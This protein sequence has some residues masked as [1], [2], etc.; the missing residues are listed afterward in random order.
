MAAIGASKFLEAKSLVRPL[1]PA[2]IAGWLGDSGVCLDTAAAVVEELGRR[3]WYSFVVPRE[4]MFCERPYNA[5]EWGF[6]LLL[7][8][9]AALSTTMCVGTAYVFIR[10]RSRRCSHRS[11]RSVEVLHLL[12]PPAITAVI[13]CYLPNE[14]H[15]IEE[16]V[17]WIMRVLESPGPLELHVVYNTPEDLPEVEARLQELQAMVWPKDRRFRATRV[18]ESTSKAANLNFAL[19]DVESPF[20]V[21]YDAD[22]HPDA[23][24]LM[25]LWR[26]LERTSADCVQGSYY[27]R[28]LGSSQFAGTTAA[29]SLIAR[30]VDAEF[31]VD[32][33][34]TKLVTRSLF[35]GSG[36]FSGSNALWRTAALAARE[37]SETAQTEDVDM[38]VQQLLDGRRIEFCPESRSGELAPTGCLALWKQRLRWTIGWDETSLKYG[39]DFADAANLSTRARCGLVWTFLV[40]WAITALTMGA[41]YMGMPLTTYWPL[42][43]ANWGGLITFLGHTCFLMGLGPWLF[44]T[45]EAIA[46]NHRRGKEGALQVASVFLVASP[47]GSALFFFFNFALQLTSLFK[48]WRGTVSGWEVT[49]RSVPQQKHVAAGPPIL[50]VELSGALP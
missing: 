3:A 32:W 29:T 50:A 38:A 30:I 20:L 40:R 31:F 13:P 39:G 33:H 44:A 37:F 28:G 5:F 43:V 14:Q 2:A 45:L 22:H 24:S 49:E 41:V 12:E 6:A 21:I 26:T 4:S 46:Q 10:S 19:R 35:L 18:R 15:I 34:L 16:T 27:M 48:L 36:Y 25:L 17:E 42:S 7:F 23:D 11:P 8:V 1:P 47:L 9:M